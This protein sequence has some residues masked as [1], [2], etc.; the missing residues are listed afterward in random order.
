MTRDRWWWLAPTFVIVLGFVAAEVSLAADARISFVLI[1]LGVMLIPAALINGPMPAFGFDASRVTERRLH[2]AA[3]IAL[4][5]GGVAFAAFGR[6]F[7]PWWAALLPAT[8][9]YWLYAWLRAGPDTTPE[10]VAGVFD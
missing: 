4:V 8:L 2:R 5:L 9:C 3:A 6:S 1:A 10:D 7:L